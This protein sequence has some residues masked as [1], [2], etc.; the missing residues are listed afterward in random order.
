MLYVLTWM[1]TGIVVGWTVR[2]AMKTQH[3]FGL[4][5]DLLTGSLGAI[6]GGWIFRK[7]GIAAPGGL[8]GSLA[9]AVVGA[10]VLLGATRL[11]RRAMVAAGLPA[12]TGTV[13]SVVDFEAQ[14]A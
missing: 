8:L 13:P 10:M 1:L 3:D 12:P 5:G 6:V 11:L 7:V 4:T 2:V 14:I 9:V